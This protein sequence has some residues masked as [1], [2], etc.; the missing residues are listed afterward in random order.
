MPWQKWQSQLS[1]ADNVVDH[2]HCAHR[3]VVLACSPC[4]QIMVS[5]TKQEGLILPASECA[6]SGSSSVAL[7]YMVIRRLVPERW[8]YLAKWYTRNTW[9]FI[10]TAVRTWN[11]ALFFLI[12]WLLLLFSAHSMKVIWNKKKTICATLQRLDSQ[13]FWTVRLSSCCSYITILLRSRKSIIR[14]SSRMSPPSVEA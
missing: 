1:N 13:S 5:Y 11:N 9:I 12:V 4:S 2:C 3:Q 6:A 8:S 14:V 10:N 7:C